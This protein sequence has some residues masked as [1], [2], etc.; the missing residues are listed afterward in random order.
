[1]KNKIGKLF[2]LSTLDTDYFNDGQDKIELVNGEALTKKCSKY[3]SLVNVSFRES[4]YFRRD[5]DFDRAIEA[6]KDAY[7]ATFDLTE[8]T[9]LRYGQL[10]RSTI[11]E[12][13]ENI[14][15]ELKYLSKGIIIKRKRFQSS[16]ETAVNTLEELKNM[17]RGV[18]FNL[19]K[20]K[21]HFIEN[22]QKKYVS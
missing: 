6:L 5:K 7:I 3:L 22:Y 4:D 17:N 16:Y 13:L 21:K 10:F 19:K 15:A 9:C 2:N 8:S 20:D 14:H 1:M 18:R 12:S 11:L